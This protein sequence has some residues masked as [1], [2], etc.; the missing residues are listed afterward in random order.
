[1][2]RVLR[3][4]FR[5]G[6]AVAGQHDQSQALGLQITQG[7]R[8]RSLDRIRDADQARGLPVH[9]D[10]DHGLPLAPQLLGLLRQ[11]RR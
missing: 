1:M 2:P 6:T 5:R 8:R 10:E 11:R 3:Y 7:L 9:R 4:C